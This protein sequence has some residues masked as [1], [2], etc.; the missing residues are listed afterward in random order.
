MKNYSHPVD[1]FY[2]HFSRLQLPKGPLNTIHWSLCVTY[3]FFP[4]THAIIRLNF[5]CTQFND[6]WSIE[7]Q[8]EQRNII[9]N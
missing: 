8:I 6:T 7:Q 3:E 5:Y 9:N 4:S 1:R 2:L